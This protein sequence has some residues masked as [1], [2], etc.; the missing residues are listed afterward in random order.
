MSIAAGPA[1][2][3]GFVLAAALTA[4][5]VAIAQP[6]SA[7]LFDD[8]RVAEPDVLRARAATGETSFAVLVN[9][10]QP[11]FHD[12]RDAARAS[13]HRREIR[14]MTSAALDRLPSA[15]VAVGHRLENQAT[16]S[17]RVTARGMALLLA[18]PDV[19]SIEIDHEIPMATA[20]GVAV[21][22]AA[23]VRGEFD[24]SGIAIGIADTGVQYTHEALGGTPFPNVKVIGGYDFGDHDAD[25]MDQNGHGTQVAGVAAG[26]VVP[27]GDYVGGVAPGA[28]IYALKIVT[29]GTA[30]STDSNEAAA[31]DWCVTHQY[32]DP[33]APIRVIN[34][35]FAGS[36]FS[37]FCDGSRTA[38]ARAANN[39][40]AAGI[41]VFCAAGN[42]GFC[43]S[44]GSPACIANTIAVGAVYDAAIGT[45]TYCVSVASCSQTSSGSCSSTKS[46]TDVTAA[47]QVACFSNSANILDILAPSWNA[48]VPHLSQG[49]TTSFG[50]TSAASPYAAGAAAVLL[51]AAREVGVS[52]PPDSV[53]A[54]LVA[55]GD[56]RFDPKS[57]ITKPRV[58]LERAVGSLGTWVDFAHAGAETG[59]PSEP[60]HTLG[61]AVAATPTGGTLVLRAGSSAERLTIAKPLTLR[62]IHG[63]TTIGP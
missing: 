57:A 60:F 4:S 12:W 9:L 13:Q 19:E 54:R 47:D 17:A 46:C 26:D 43:S 58:N 24:G 50:G 10:Q 44:I 7:D 28:R 52:M 37:S 51:H 15:E 34:T 45:R 6:R 48:S 29:G 21:M 56:G 49:Y 59:T 41:T 39:A 31:W 55:T 1:S 22:N 5:S 53:R 14:R 16:F 61:G 40:V 3:A 23:F 20:Q 18:D 8:P 38:L 42:D 33:S 36:R 27:H 63:T 30:S 32:D 11:A 35:S 2:I 25:P 62:S